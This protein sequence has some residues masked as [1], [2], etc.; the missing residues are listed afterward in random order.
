MLENLYVF[1]CEVFAFDN[2]WVFKNAETN[3][4]FIFHNDNEGVMTFMKDNPLLVGYNNKDYDQF[5]LRAV[6][7]DMTPEEVKRVN[8][9]IIL[10][11]IAGWNI[12]ELQDRGI[13]CEQFDLMD[14]TQQGTSLKDI[15]GHLGMDIQETTVPFDIDRP[16]TETEV[17]EVIKYCKHDVD[18][19]HILLKLREVYIANKLTIGREK[20]MV[21]AKAL[22][23]TNAK[24]AAAYLDA[25][26][27][28]HDDEREYVFPSDILWE[29]I[30]AEVKAFFGRIHDKSIPDDDLWNQSIKI[31][32]GE[33]ETK[34]GWGGIHGAINHYSEE[35]EI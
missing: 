4:Y 23:M 34:L 20:G 29:Y 8:D 27:K 15:E 22:Y 16:L 14:D 24:L 19:T 1:D 10:R 18:A 31:M 26:P 2:L 30:P 11:G 25:T 32:V 21:P 5:I 17:A 13:Y 33:C 28:K 12:P 7:I 9:Q 6:L 3:D 35:G